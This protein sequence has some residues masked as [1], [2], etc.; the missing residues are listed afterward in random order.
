MACGFV[1]CCLFFH[2]PPPPPPP[3]LLSGKTLNEDIKGNGFRESGV[4]RGGGGVSHQGGLLSWKGC[5]VLRGLTECI[6]LQG[7]F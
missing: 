2:I 6:C 5:L 1:A 4:K 3:L 7:H